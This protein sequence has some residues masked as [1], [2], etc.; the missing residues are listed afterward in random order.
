MNKNTIFASALAVAGTA[1]ALSGAAPA[2]ALKF[3]WSFV[4]DGGLSSG[5]GGQTISGTIDGLQEGD[6]PGDTLIVTVLSTPTGELTGSGWTFS[7]GAGFFVTGETIALFDAVYTRNGGTETLNF[8]NDGGNVSP[9]LADSVNGIAWNSS[10]VT[11]FTD[12]AALPEPG[13]VVAL[14][15]LGA[16]G[17]AGR[18]LRG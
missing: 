14:L 9:S 13:S 1:L 18:K 4:I 3:N 15:G 7:G 16:L 12:P 2:N 6:N 5:G 11:T 10:G 8:G 17:V